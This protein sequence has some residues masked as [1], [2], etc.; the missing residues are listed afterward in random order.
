VC[1]R[2][3]RDGKEEQGTT[4]GRTKKARRELDGDRIV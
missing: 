4:L 3:E 2:E 1:E